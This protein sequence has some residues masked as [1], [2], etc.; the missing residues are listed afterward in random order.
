[1]D[2]HRHGLPSPVMPEYKTAPRRKN[3]TLLI[4]MRRTSPGFC[5]DFNCRNFSA[6]ILTAEIF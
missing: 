2:A 1:M 4:Q 6:K 3:A 5:K